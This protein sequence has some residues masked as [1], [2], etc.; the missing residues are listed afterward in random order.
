M[1][2]NDFTIWTI[3]TPHK[4]EDGRKL[5]RSAH[6][7]HAVG[8]AS[9]IEMKKAHCGRGPVHFHWLA[10]CELQSAIT[11]IISDSKLNHKGN[12]QYTSW[13]AGVQCM[14]RLIVGMHLDLPHIKHT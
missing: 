4:Y 2:A 13:A 3:Y 7:C 1:H 14:L 8:L 10:T 12:M 6:A 9:L 11:I 5:V